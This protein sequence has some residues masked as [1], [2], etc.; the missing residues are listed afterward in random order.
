MAG[1]DIGKDVRGRDLSRHGL[2]QADLTDPD[3]S[4]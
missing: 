1:S 2:A 3:V 4:K